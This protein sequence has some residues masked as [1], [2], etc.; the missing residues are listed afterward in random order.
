MSIQSNINQG[1]SLMSLLF[2][3]TPG[4]AA[5]REGVIQ[6]VAE[7]K[8]Q[9]KIA[10]EASEQE[11][12]Y[13]ALQKHAKEGI[14][15]ATTKA[16][17]AAEDDLYKELVEVSK[18]RYL[19]NPSKA[20][21]EDYMTDVQ[22]YAESKQSKQAEAEKKAKE[23][24]DAEQTRIFRSKFLEGIYSSNNVREVKKYGKE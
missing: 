21:Y 2:S 7:S 11:Q 17:E 13:S 14:A 5:K 10:T 3:Q 1:L 9:E 16:E 12:R 23:A 20:T 15:K 4:A 19:A 18:Q 22:G 24:L 6:S 8:A